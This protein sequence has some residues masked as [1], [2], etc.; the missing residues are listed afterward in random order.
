MNRPLKA[1]TLRTLAA[2]SLAALMLAGCTLEPTYRQPALPTPTAFPQADA[3]SASGTPA[4]AIPWRTFFR[5][6]K[7]Q[8]TV[9]L[10]LANNRDLRVAIANI[11]VAR[12]Q[13]RVQRA[14]LLP[15]INATG[16]ATYGRESAASTGVVTPGEP[17]HF[18]IHEY[19]ASVG[20]TGYELD[21]FGRVR[22]LTKAALEQYFATKE[23]RR[24]AQITLVSEV[25]GD[26]ITLAADKAML[27]S[28][29][30]TLASTQASLDVAQR[31]FDYGIASQLDVRQAETLVQQTR[32]DVAN[33]ATTVAQ[34]KNALD[35]VAGAPVPDALL[36]SA[37]GDQTMTLTELPAGLPSEV[38]LARPDVLQAEDQLK[39]QNAQIGAARAAF[40]P[41][42]TLTGS[43][44]GTSTSLSTLF[45]GASGVWTFA[46][47]ITLPIFA[48]GANVAN[49]DLAK[50][51]K[52]V[53]VAQYEK[54]IQS[55]FRDVANALARQA[56]I[57]D[58]VAANEAAVA[59]AADTVKLSQARYERGSDTYLNVLI[60]QRT[61]YAAE[62]GLIAA[63]LTRAVNFVTLY[64]A[65]GGGAAP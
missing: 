56:T 7:L 53:S 50:A 37:L 45:K 12:A 19:T 42:I 61:L 30:E 2:P 28:A 52:D 26:Y 29:Q 10:A 55:A 13:Y 63:R 36:P 64:T 17:N 31:R 62:E 4:A 5:D 58:Q 14:E 9:E 44:G 33:D 39:A 23:A 47:Q 41:S 32:S 1:L 38:L 57:G 35:L 8:A 6:P 3:A 51:Q 27:Q 18:N 54:A 59:A 15:Q 11:E 40:F 21:L 34:D 48:G 49:L 43:G 22:S 25:A 65:L 60:A 46:P 24:A 16:G 20:V